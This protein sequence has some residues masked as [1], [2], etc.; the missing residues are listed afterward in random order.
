MSLIKT[1]RYSYWAEAESVSSTGLGVENQ[2]DAISDLLNPTEEVDGE[3]EKTQAKDEG[4]EDSVKGEDEQKSGEE[5]EASGSTDESS[6]ESDT[7]ETWGSA[8]GVDDNLLSVDDSGNL[9][10]FNV[11]VDGET[12]TVSAS[13]LIAGYQSNKSNTQRGQQNASDRKKFEEVRDNA[14]VAYTKKLEDVDALTKYVHGTLT[15]EFDAVNWDELRRT[16]PAE[17][18]ALQNDFQRRNG[19]IQDVFA[20]IQSEKTEEETNISA[21]TKEQLQSHLAS[22]MDIIVQNNPEWNDKARMKEGFDTLQKGMSEYGYTPE[23]FAM[24]QDARVIEVL[25]DALK[26]RQGKQVAQKKIT[27]KLPTYQKSTGKVVAKKDSK[28][29]Q[30][31]KLAKKSKGANKRS[32]QDDAIAELLSQ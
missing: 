23:D 6:G 8:I 10:G 13:D 26:Y 3:L 18:A 28:L 2:I 31:T 9:A 17:Y 20:A 29:D 4:A 25:K 27:P 30:L 32:L 14:V 1:N 7:E 11:K 12:S 21:R 24:I 15:K 5:D 16:D 19:E 22:Q